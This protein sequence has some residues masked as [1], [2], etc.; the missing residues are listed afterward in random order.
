M[1]LLFSLP[2]ISSA[3]VADDLHETVRAAILA[4]PRT[5][6]MSEAEIEE[7]VVALTEE[8]TVQGITS[9]DIAWRPQEA[10]EAE[11]T[12]CENVPEFLCALNRAFG[13]DGSDAKIPIGLGVSSALLLFLIGSILLH[14]Y[15]HHP[16]A[17][18]L[19]SKK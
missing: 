12:G 5:S 14:Q 7:M 18:Q 2:I 3:Q 13:F 4:D 8:A 10:K 16:F 17:G 1:V 6:L 15:G 11:S 9:A 19:L